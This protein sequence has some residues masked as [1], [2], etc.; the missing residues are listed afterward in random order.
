MR[1]LSLECAQ[2]SQAVESLI[3]SEREII[4]K[5]QSESLLDHGDSAEAPLD[6][7]DVQ[8]AE[9]VS[10]FRFNLKNQ[11]FAQTFLITINFSSKYFRACSNRKIGKQVDKAWLE[12]HSPSKFPEA[13]MQPFD[14]SDFE[15]S[16]ICEHVLPPKYTILTQYVDQAL[17]LF[18]FQPQSPLAFVKDSGCPWLMRARGQRFGKSDWHT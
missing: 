14:D 18:R 6:S 3:L 16:D 8:V 15:V 13:L 5:S 12:R 1:K 10:R 17:W 7:V 9:R 2:R 11:L 4:H